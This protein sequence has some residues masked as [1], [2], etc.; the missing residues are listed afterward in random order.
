MRDAAR[1][2]QH[3]LPGQG[4]FTSPDNR[5]ARLGQLITSVTTPKRTGVC[6]AIYAAIVARSAVV[7]LVPEA[8]HVVGLHRLR[9]DRMARRGVPAHVTVL[10]PFRAVV[11]DVTAARG[12]DLCQRFE[13]FFATFAT[14]GR[15]PGDVLWLRPEPSR[16]FAALTR[17]FADEFPD[18]PPYGGAYVDPIPHLTVGSGLETATA[19]E[20]EGTLIAQ[21][22]VSTHVDR[23]TV[24]LEDDAGMWTVGPS[25]PLALRP[26]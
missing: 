4:C 22:P 21:L 18:C 17:A 13:P 6:S 19:D 9:H 24:L 5:P 12:A 16:A 11:D 2:G 7:V 1:D 25:W 8:E 20:I 3:D 23:L 14:V 15:F 26:D 10:H